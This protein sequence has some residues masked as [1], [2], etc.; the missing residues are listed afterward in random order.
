MAGWALLLLGVLYAAWGWR[1]VKK[2]R[3]HKHFDAYEDGTLYV[4]EHREGEVVYPQQRH[5]V[6]PWVMFVIFALAPNEPMIPLLSILGIGHNAWNVAAFVAVYVAATV[7]TMLVMV[8]MGYYGLSFFTTRAL[9]KYL[10][11]LG[12]L[13]LIISGISMVWASS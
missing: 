2:N 9:E 1:Q 8:L 3:R 4:Y 13:A 6:T 10:P 11:L 7:I 5:I 12:G